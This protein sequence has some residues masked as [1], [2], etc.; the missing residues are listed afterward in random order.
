MAQSV[1]CLT[2]DLASGHD[3]TVHGIEPHIGLCT[4]SMEPALDSLFASLS[5]PFPLVYTHTLSLSK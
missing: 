4:D 3:L 1:K 2:L 5:A